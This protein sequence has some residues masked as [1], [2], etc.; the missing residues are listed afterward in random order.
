[1]GVR[2]KQFICVVPSSRASLGLL[3]PHVGLLHTLTSTLQ[4][5]YHTYTITSFPGLPASSPAHLPSS[6]SRFC[7]GR[8]LLCFPAG[9]DGCAEPSQQILKAQGS[10]EVYFLNWKSPETDA[11]PR[12][13]ASAITC[14]WSQMVSPSLSSISSSSRLLLLCVCVS[15]VM[16]DC[17]WPHGLEPSRFLCLLSM[18]FSRQE[19]WSGLPFPS[20]GIFLTQGPNLSLFHVLY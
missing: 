13:H 14:C 20:P 4:Q 16:T 7:P 6:S 1:M 11:S 9:W 18:G 5:E 8:V 2:G 17:L 10:P 19:Y 15:S 12:F 3:S